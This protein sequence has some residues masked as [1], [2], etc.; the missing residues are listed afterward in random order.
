MRIMD[1]MKGTATGLGA[2]RWAPRCLALNVAL[3]LAMVAATLWHNAS[4]PD[5]RLPE[6]ANP[7]QALSTPQAAL[8]LPT[9]QE[10][11]HW[12]LNAVIGRADAGRFPEALAQRAHQMGWLTRSAQDEEHSMG[13]TLPASQLPLIATLPADPVRWILSQQAPPYT[14]PPARDPYVN[15]ALQVNTVREGPATAYWTVRVLQMISVASFIPMFIV[16]FSKYLP[17]ADY[18]SGRG[19]YPPWLA[20]YHRNNSWT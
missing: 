14:D 16:F 4:Q 1:I 12:R 8:A 17:T 3:V 15:V 6:A 5:P 13:I 11:P 18:F 2:S 19:G 9:A 7:P 20:E 10:P